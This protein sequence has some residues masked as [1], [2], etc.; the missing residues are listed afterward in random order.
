MRELNAFELTLISGGELEMEMDSYMS[1]EA[2][3]S[4]SSS[5]AYIDQIIQTGVNA[6]NE[7]LASHPVQSMDAVEAYQAA[8]AAD[9]ATAAQDRSCNNGLIGGAIAG[10]PGGILG[11]IVGTIGGGIAGGCLDPKIAPAKR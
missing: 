8:R 6:N 3:G 10:L 11:A 1:G 5:D 9:P 2:G 4:G 7:W